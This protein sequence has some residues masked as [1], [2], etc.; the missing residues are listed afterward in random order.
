MVTD[1]FNSII[2]NPFLDI[3]G[4]KLWKFTI[5]VAIGFIIFLLILKN[6]RKKENKKLDDDDWRGALF[7]GFNF[8]AFL[9]TIYFAFTGEFLFQ[10]KISSLTAMAIASLSI[11]LYIKRNLK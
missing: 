3:L 6:K 5:I 8:Y 1:L 2:L 4:I 9:F 10:D 11:F 7:L